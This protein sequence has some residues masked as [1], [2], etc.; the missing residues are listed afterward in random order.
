VATAAV[1]SGSPLAGDLQQLAR[2]S[3]QAIETSRNI[4]R[5]V[6]PLTESRGS[7]VQSL[8]KLADSAGAS[9][10]AHIDFEA[11]ENVPLRL[12][13]EARDHLHRI[14]QQALSNALQHSGAKR[15]KIGIEIDARLVRLEI[16]DDGRG[17]DASSTPKGLGIDGM[18]QRAAAIGGR[19]RFLD[20]EP[21]G[22]A[23][24][25][26]VQQPA[27]PAKASE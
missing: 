1:R 4:A 18:R 10:Q 19:L 27:A 13:W 23:V 26:E 17:F 5:G 2:L 24:V 21:G 8:R 14:A 7:L 9:H 25:C 3:A 12:P 20:N 15:I 11:I 22:T 6:S 16:A